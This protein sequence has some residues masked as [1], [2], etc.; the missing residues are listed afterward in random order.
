MLVAAALFQLVSGILNIA[1]WYSPMPFFFI[2]GH[3][4]VAWLAIGAL[5]LHIGVKL[6]IVRARA[7][8]GRPA[9]APGHAACPAGVA[10]R[11]SPPRSVRHA[12]HGR[13]DRPA[14]AVLSVLAPRRPD[15]G[16]QGFP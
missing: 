10:R 15:I 13:A 11:S 2:A 5:L 3:Y 9:P 12:R 6:P 7:D 16:P 4:W 1:R 8:A 14:A